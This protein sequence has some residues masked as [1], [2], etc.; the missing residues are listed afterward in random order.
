[1]SEAL[2]PWEGE[3]LRVRVGAEVALELWLEAGLGREV[4]QYSAG[5]AVHPHPS[6]PPSQGQGDPA[7]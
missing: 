6:P 5:K 4:N 7:W 2:D 1:M 3:A